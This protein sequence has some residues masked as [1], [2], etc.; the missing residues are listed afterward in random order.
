[1][2]R[3]NLRPRPLASGSPEIN[4]TPLIDVVF[5]ILIS[6][7]VVAPLLDLDNIELAGG[8]EGHE[9]TTADADKSP[10]R[11]HVYQDNSLRLN[12]QKLLLPQLKSTLA[13]MHTQLP[14]AK[15]LIF[16]D[17]RAHFGTYQEVK[18]AVE[19]AGFEE[20]DVVLTPR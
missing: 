14:G 1:M 9:Q 10:I 4:L 8:I 16:H 12:E 2:P 13:K 7:M 17:R 3:R 15:P 18:N 19:I 11:I 20:M 5:V 6:F